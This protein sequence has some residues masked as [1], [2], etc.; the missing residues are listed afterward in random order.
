MDVRTGTRFACPCS[1]PTR[2]DTLALCLAVLVRRACPVHPPS[3]CVV[4]SFPR[5]AK[6]IA[7]V[8]FADEEDAQLTFSR[9]VGELPV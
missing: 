2:S 4:N 7:N 6:V 3:A 9:K 5:D 8:D 1:V